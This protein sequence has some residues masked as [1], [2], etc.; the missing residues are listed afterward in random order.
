MAVIIKREEGQAMS[1]KGACSYSFLDFG[2]RP[3]SLFLSLNLV[4]GWLLNN[5]TNTKRDQ[6]L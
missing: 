3:V 2:C 1:K 6:H 5:R 4:P